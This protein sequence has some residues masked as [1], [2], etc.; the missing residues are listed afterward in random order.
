MAL[1]LNDV[2]VKPK[3]PDMCGPGSIRIPWTGV[4]I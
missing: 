2:D 3:V 1:L 4:E